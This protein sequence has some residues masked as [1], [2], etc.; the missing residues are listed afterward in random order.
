MAF[1]DL[2]FVTNGRQG[3]PSV[4]LKHEIA[5]GSEAL[6]RAVCAGERLRE[7][8]TLGC[9]ENLLGSEWH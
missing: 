3:E 1:D 4:P 6:G 7:V 8:P 5:I 9:S 2:S